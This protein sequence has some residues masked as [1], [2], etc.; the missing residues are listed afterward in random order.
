MI[1]GISAVITLVLLACIM[2]CVMFVEI[3]TAEHLSLFWNGRRNLQTRYSSSDG[4]LVQLTSC[5]RF[6]PHWCSFLSVVTCTIVWYDYRGVVWSRMTVSHT[7]F[8]KPKGNPSWSRSLNCYCTAVVAVQWG[9]VPHN[10][11]NPKKSQLTRSS[12]QSYWLCSVVTR[13]FTWLGVGAD[14]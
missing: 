12:R 5:P 4:A 3:Y 1:T 7:W 13:A 9:I 10:I 11:Q 6:K 2:F 8:R 14:P